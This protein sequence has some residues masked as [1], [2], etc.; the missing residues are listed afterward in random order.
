MRNF[1]MKCSRCRAPADHR[2]PAHNARFCDDCLILF[3]NRQVERAI[4]QFDMLE[5]GQTVAVAVSGGKDSLALWDVLHELGYETKA[6][7]LVLDLPDFGPQSLEACQAM[8]HRLGQELHISD[9]KELSGLSMDELWR[10]SHREYCSVCGTMKRYY[11]NR[12]CHDL[13]CEVL[14]TGHNLDDEAGRLLGNLIRRNERHLLRQW[15]VLEG[16]SADVGPGLSK[17]IKPLCR[18]SVDELKIYAKI[19]DLPVAHG[20]CPRNRGATLLYY[21]EAM[22]FLD[23]NMPGTKR[24]MYFGF[25]DEKGGPPPSP[26]PVG[27][28][29]VCAAPS[30]A[31]VCIACRLILRAKKRG[32]K[33]AKGQKNRSGSV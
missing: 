14:A 11:L 15:P 27:R 31:E 12:L 20:S 22:D 16:M 6:V 23:Q 21:Q 25:L 28:C 9:V 3:V 32:A 10:G 18:L 5:P 30:H 24:N 19:R 1:G 29:Q 7:H 2:F 4:K 13:G 26:D 17:K 33:A 8:A